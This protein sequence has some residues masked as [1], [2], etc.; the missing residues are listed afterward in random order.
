MPTKE[1]KFL[2]AGPTIEEVYARQVGKCWLEIEFDDIGGKKVFGD[3]FCTD[4]KEKFPTAA[5]LNPSSECTKCWAAF[6]ESLFE[7][8]EK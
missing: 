3:L 5:L 4:G 8:E 6:I 2:Y 7:N 1:D